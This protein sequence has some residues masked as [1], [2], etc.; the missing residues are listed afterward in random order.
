MA[1]TVEAVTRVVALLTEI[2]GLTVFEGTVPKDPPRDAEGR[3]K[4]YVCVYMG[5]GETRNTRYGY[6]PRDLSLPIWVTCSAGTPR[7]ANWAVDK[8]R[9]VLNG[10]R[11]FATPEDPRL[12][13]SRLREVTE[14]V[15]LREDR[16]I[17]TD[18]RWFLP[19]QYRFATTI[20]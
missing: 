12:G 15:A 3:V 17:P 1:T 4:P 13:D 10:V 16:D 5:S 9:P 18:L 6:K 19:M 2:D 7:G 14:N 20:S 8:V 11:L